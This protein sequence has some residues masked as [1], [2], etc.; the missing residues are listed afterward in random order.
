MLVPHSVP[1]GSSSKSQQDPLGPNHDGMLPTVFDS[2]QQVIDWIPSGS[3]EPELPEI[4]RSA[5]GSPRAPQ[6]AQNGL[7]IKEYTLNCIGI[8]N[9]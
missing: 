7:I 9:L 2:K 5:E 8:H 4:K 1:R 3:M 6:R